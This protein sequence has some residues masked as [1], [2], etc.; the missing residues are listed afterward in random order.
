TDRYSDDQV[1]FSFVVLDGVVTV[2]QPMSA[3]RY[4]E[5]GPISTLS[6]VYLE[7]EP[8]NAELLDNGEFA[9]NLIPHTLFALLCGVLALGSAFSAFTTLRRTPSE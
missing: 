6:A 7:G 3:D 5:L 4:A 9:A 1:L 2:A 8:E